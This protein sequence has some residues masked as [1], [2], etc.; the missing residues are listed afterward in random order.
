MKLQILFELFINVN[1]NKHN[2]ELHR[3]DPGT[4][5]KGDF[6][7]KGRIFQ[8]N[9]PKWIFITSIVLV[10]KNTLK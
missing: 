10:R 7:N 3:T 4:K 5:V 6:S 9:D 1:I 8:P 2:A